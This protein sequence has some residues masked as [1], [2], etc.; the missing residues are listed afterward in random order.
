MSIPRQAWARILASLLASL[1][2]VLGILGAPTPAAADE[3]ELTEITDGT[4]VWGFKK[5]WRNYTGPTAV[6]LS[7][8]VKVGETGEYVWPI[9]QGTFNKTTNATRM[10]TGLTIAMLLFGWSEMS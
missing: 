1:S 5:S 8:G 7:G 9:K 6:T 4:V 10:S 2:L 3:S